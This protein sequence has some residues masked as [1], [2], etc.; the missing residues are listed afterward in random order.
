MGLCMLHIADMFIFYTSMPGTCVHL[1][2][3][4]RAA[5]REC[6]ALLGP[7]VQLRLSKCFPKPIISSIISVWLWPQELRHHWPA[8]AAVDPIY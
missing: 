8:H 4:S 5:E 6:S 3:A 2:S 7:H 1:S